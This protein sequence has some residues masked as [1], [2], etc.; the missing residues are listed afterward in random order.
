[1]SNT[2]AMTSNGG[3]VALFA[4]AAA[5]RFYVACA[6]SDNSHVKYAAAATDRP[7]GL[8]IDGA[9]AAED[10]VAILR[11]GKGGE[12][13][14]VKMS[15]AG[16]K[17]QYVCPAIDGSGKARV[18]PATAG[19][20]WAFARLEE[21]AVDGQE[22]VVAD[23]EPMLVGPQA[24]NGQLGI[25]A[26][27]TDP[28]PVPGLMYNNTADNSVKLYVN[29]AWR[30]LQ[31]V[32]AM[33]LL[34]AL[35]AALA[36]AP[37]AAAADKTP[38]VQV[39]A[40]TGQIAAAA[41]ADN[42]KIPGSLEVVGNITG[43]G[44]IGRVSKAFTRADMTDNTNTTGYIDFATQIPAGALV[45]GW[46]AVTTTGFTGD[47]TATIKV[48]ISGGVGDYSTVTSGSVLGAG[49]VGSASVLATSFCAA[50]TTAR[51]TITGAADFT[52]IAAGS[53]TV[54]VFYAY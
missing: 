26:F 30:V 12:T 38:M 3:R 32:A 25:P 10:L 27:A 37:S 11:F 41:G 40:T 28:T 33:L 2:R 35:L 20:Y 18:V 39:S 17:G 47:T 46:K 7:L 50:A 49:T 42:V 8:F 31:F 1:M 16:T 52:S 13:K 6:G 21:D 14:V 36:Y 48:G 44:F 4:A 51:V 45:L 9:D 23:F 34:T 29:G 54:T 24:A 53:C 22:A 19:A 5:S 43:A 15:G